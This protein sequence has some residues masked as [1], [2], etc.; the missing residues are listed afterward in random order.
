MY[1]NYPGI[2]WNVIKINLL[3][4]LCDFSFNPVKSTSGAGYR[5]NLNKYNDS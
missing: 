3:I 5:Q 4:L 1:G 2:D